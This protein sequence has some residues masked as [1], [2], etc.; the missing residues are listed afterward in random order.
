VF[1]TI[2]ISSSSSSSSSTSTSGPSPV[3]HHHQGHH[4]VIIIIIIIIITI[5]IKPF[6]IDLITIIM[7]VMVLQGG[8]APNADGNMDAGSTISLPIPAK[9][10]SGQ[11]GLTLDSFTLAVQEHALK[12]G[13]VILQGVAPRQALSR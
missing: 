11:L 4:I 10:Y 7:Y 2:F 8:G 5:I 12:G 9:L 6:M 13:H 1:T 3:N